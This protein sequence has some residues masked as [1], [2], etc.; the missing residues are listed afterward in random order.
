MERGRKVAHSIVRL[1]IALTAVCLAGY[2]ILVAWML[3]DLFI[4]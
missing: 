4:G 1:L 3:W 2:A